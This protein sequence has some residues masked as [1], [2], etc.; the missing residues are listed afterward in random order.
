MV[1]EL[2]H[3]E[4][5][6]FPDQKYTKAGIADYYKRIASEMLP[7]IKERPITLKRYPEGIAHDGFFHKKASDYFFSHLPIVELPRRQRQ[8]TISMVMVNTPAHLLYLVNYSTIEFHVGLSKVT[9]IE[10]PDQIIFDFDP[11][12]NDFE[13]VRVAALTLKEL[14]EQKGLI[15][16][17]KT[18]GSRGLHVHLPIQAEHSF[19]EIKPIAKSLAAELLEKLPEITTMEQRINKRDDKVFIDYLRNDYGMTAIAPY[20]LRALAEAPVATPI[21]WH[22]LKQNQLTARSYHIKNIFRR[23]GQVDDPWKDFDKVAEQNSRRLAI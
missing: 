1:F 21:F 12:D 4:K 22:E 16:F 19:K 17:V 23:L 18:T 11:S 5:I 9:A 15:C 10:Q 2:S 6:L 14:L 20:S 8:G 13:K 3:P 7:L